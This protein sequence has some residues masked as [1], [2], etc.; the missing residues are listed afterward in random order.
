MRVAGAP[1][2]RESGGLLTHSLG[3]LPLRRASQHKPIRFDDFVWKETLRK[4]IAP[5]IQITI[6]G[7]LERIGMASWREGQHDTLAEQGAY[8]VDDT[9]QIAIGGNEQRC[10]H[11]ILHGVSQ[12]LD[13]DV[14]VGHLLMMCL[15]GVATTRTGDLVGEEMTVENV[16]IREGLQSLQKNRL[17]AMAPF[18][19]FDDG[20][21]VLNFYQVLIG[22]EQILDKRLQVQPV[23]PFP[24]LG[25]QTIVQV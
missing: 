14:Y 5:D 17:A 20:G 7:L 18:G 6:A 19:T 15:V 11:S 2:L 16:K 9:Y 22:F 10:V 4:Y 24:S 13:S 23:S 3:L 1:L 8:L 12:H 25:A 21:E